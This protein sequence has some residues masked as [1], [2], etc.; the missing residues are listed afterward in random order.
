MYALYVCEL[1]MRNMY[2]L[3]F[4]YA[5]YVR[6]AFYVCEICMFCVLCMR[7]MYVLRFMYAKYVCLVYGV[8]VVYSV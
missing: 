3:R 1:Y 7:F 8:E 2:V 6:F 4:M 5:I